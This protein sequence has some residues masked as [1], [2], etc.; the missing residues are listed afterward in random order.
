[1]AFKNIDVDSHVGEPISVIMDEYLESEFKDNPIRLLLDEKG[2]EYAEVDGKKSPIIQGGVGISVDAGMGFGKD[3]LTDLFTPGK[4][5]YEEALTPESYQPE[6]RLK[7]MDSEDIDIALQY[8]TLGLFWEEG[9]ENPKTAAAYAR[10]Y[11][12]WIVD[13]CKANPDRLVPIAHIPNKDV[14]ESVKEVKRTAKLGVK[15]FM[16]HSICYNGRL[17][18]DEYYDPLFAAVEETGIPLAVHPIG[19]VNYPGRDRYSDS[20]SDSLFLLNDY[21]YTLT[22]DPFPIQITFLNMINRGVFDRFPNLKFVL[23]ETGGAWILYWLERMEDRF[24]TAKSTV[25]FKLS[26]DEYFNRQCWISFE[27]DEKLMANIIEEVGADRFLWAA[28]FPHADGF[29]GI[30]GRVKE[31]IEPLSEQDKLKILGENAAKLYG[32]KV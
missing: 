20:N 18:G 1:M 28:D 2:L 7:W 9:C 26:P 23:L 3:D 16:I 10:A 8:P 25:S 31:A 32:L 6:A 11:N 21:W 5:R 19:S 27:P 13:M 17:W 30:V 22:A 12:N 4:V 29:P 24:K 15:G 14:E